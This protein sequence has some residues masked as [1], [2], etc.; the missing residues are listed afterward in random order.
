[1]A[2]WCVETAIYDSLQALP[3]DC[4]NKV[5][6]QRHKF[7]ILRKLITYVGSS[8][9]CD[10]DQYTKMFPS[11]AQGV[12]VHHAITHQLA[13]YCVMLWKCYF[14]YCISLRLLCSNIPLLN[15]PPP[16]FPTPASSSSS[17][18]VQYHHS[19]SSG[20]TYS[21]IGQRNKKLHKEEE[22]LKTKTKKQSRYDCYFS[23]KQTCHHYPDR[24]VWLREKTGGR[25]LFP[26]HV[27]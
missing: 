26:N 20:H 23:V 3:V 9:A 25:F 16:Y 17:P 12:K 8:C 6:P 5:K 27:Q 21:H 19:V 13:Q 24:F 18:L 14:S 2:T 11:H 10:T 4:Q 15:P 7:T 22:N 1:M